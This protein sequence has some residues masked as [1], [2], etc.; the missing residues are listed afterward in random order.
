[1]SGVAWWSQTAANNAT[2][3]PAI[4]WAEGQS[5]SSVN[6]SARALMASAAKWRDD[7]AGAIATGG[8]STAYTVTSHQSFDAISRLNGQMIAFVPHTTNTGACTLNV[9][10]L[11]AAPIRQFHNVDLTSGVL[12]QN[13]PYL[14][15][16]NSSAGEF[17]LHNS[18]GN[19]YN[20]P[21]GGLMP[22]TGSAAPNSS[23]VL[24]YGQAIS[25]TTYSSLFS[26]LG[27]TY[28]SGDGSTTFNV[29]DLRGRVVAGLDTMGGS[30]AGRLT[31]AAAGFGDGLGESGGAQTRTLITANL[32]PY[33]P[34]GAISGTGLSSETTIQK[35]TSNITVNAG[36]SNTVPLTNNA[37]VTLNGNQFTFTGNAQGGSSTAFAIV[38]P[39]IVLN[40]LLRII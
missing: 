36:G 23:F 37:S 29:P 35:N 21:I 22:Y 27:T 7:I 38:Q 9:D 19:P 5:P 13:T 16:Y 26:L 12:I 1:M 39:T 40:Y 20:I 32:P 3:D 31:D 30:A 17:N 15:V 8:T 10:G 24:P 11:G 33:T 28:G 34:S 25:R 4:N 6:D 14:V 2:F 18:F